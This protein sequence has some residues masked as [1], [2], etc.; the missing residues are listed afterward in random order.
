MKRLISVFLILVLTISFIFVFSQ[1]SKQQFNENIQK[2]FN[3]DLDLGEYLYKGN[4]IYSESI[5]DF[6][7]FGK[8]DSTEIGFLNRQMIDPFLSKNQILKYIPIYDPTT[9][10]PVACIFLSVGED[11]VFNNYTTQK[12]HIDDWYKVINAYNLDEVRQEIEKYT[13]RYPVFNRNNGQQGW[14]LVKVNESAL[15]N[16]KILLK[17]DSLFRGSFNANSMNEFLSPKRPFVYKK[18][19]IIRK[20]F[21]NKDYIVNW[22][23]RVIE[24]QIEN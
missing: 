18:Y 17:G 7:I 1:S 2:Y 13:I 14:Y 12:L 22:G 3:V 6:F 4:K 23:C 19:S 20:F 16:K 9:T 24:Y 21:G 10:Y 15:K 5:H 8:Y 11:G